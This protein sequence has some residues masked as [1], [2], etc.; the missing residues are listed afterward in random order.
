MLLSVVQ[1]STGEVLLREEASVNVSAEVLIDL[2]GNHEPTI[3][4]DVGVLEDYVRRV[5]G[6]KFSECQIT[7][8]HENLLYPSMAPAM[9]GIQIRIASH[10][11]QPGLVPSVKFVAQDRAKISLE[12]SGLK[13]RGVCRDV[14]LTDDTPEKSDGAHGAQKGALIV[15]G[16]GNTLLALT[17][18]DG[19]GVLKGKADPGNAVEGFV[20]DVSPAHKAYGVDCVKRVGQKT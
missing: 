16:E 2:A 4:G 10:F 7:L 13:E 19:L 1:N 15:L 18:L 8:R 12:I 14:V 5:V 3:S 20:R 11:T 6:G 17:T 9:E